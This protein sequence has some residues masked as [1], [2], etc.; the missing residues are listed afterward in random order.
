[1]RGLPSDCLLFTCRNSSEGRRIEARTT[2]MNHLRRGRGEEMKYS[3]VRAALGTVVLMLLLQANPPVLRAQTPTGN[4]LGTVRDSGGGAIPG[5]SVSAKSV[6]TGAVRSAATDS[7]G[8]YQILSVPA[9]LYDP[10]SEGRRRNGG[11][12]NHGELHCRGGRRA[13][14]SGGH[15]EFAGVEHD[16]RKHGRAGGR[17]RNSRASPQRPRLVTTRDVAGGSCGRNRATVSRYFH[18]FPCGARQWSG[19]CYFRQPSDGK[20]VSRGRPC[21]E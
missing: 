6:E 9:G 4:I 5:T 11:G 21:R 10:G 13:G 1:M 16:R 2:Q 12:C 3:I 15:L 14:K 8:A 17:D 20:R 19:A 7:S 18:E